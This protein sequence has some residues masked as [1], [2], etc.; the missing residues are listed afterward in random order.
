MI[1]IVQDALKDKNIESGYWSRQDKYSDYILRRTL[2]TYPR[3]VSG[4]TAVEIETLNRCNNDCS[5]CPVNRHDDTREFHKMSENMFYNII[6]QLE[7]KI[8]IV[9]YVSWEN[10][11]IKLLMLNIVSTHSL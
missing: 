2:E 1:I 8:A 11:K 5:F 4:I 10:K 9:F 3:D 6:E 7:D